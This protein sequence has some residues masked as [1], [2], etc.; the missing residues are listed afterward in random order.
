MNSVSWLSKETFVTAMREIADRPVSHGVIRSRPDVTSMVMTMQMTV[1]TARMTMLAVDASCIIAGQLHA[2]PN[3]STVD[4]KYNR[5]SAR[6]GLRA[7]RSASQMGVQH[8]DPSCASMSHRR[9]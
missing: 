3:I 1:A 6:A 5:T 9:S 2:E 7:V 8:L 4:G